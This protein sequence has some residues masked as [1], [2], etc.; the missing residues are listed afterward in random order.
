MYSLPSIYLPFICIGKGWK[1]N[2]IFDEKE[3]DLNFVFDDMGR[4]LN[5]IFDDMGWDLKVV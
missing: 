3:R 2:V 4:D 5:S 1:L